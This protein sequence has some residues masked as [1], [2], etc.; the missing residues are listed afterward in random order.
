MIRQVAQ[1][2]KPFLEKGQLVNACDKLVRESTALWK[3]CDE[4][5]DDITAVIIAL[6]TDSLV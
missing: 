1:M 5:V 3:K 4:V 6:N 2:A